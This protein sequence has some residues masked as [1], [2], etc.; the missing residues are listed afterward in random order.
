MHGGDSM[1]ENETKLKSGS[2]IFLNMLVN[3]RER[4]HQN[5]F[6]E[7]KYHCNDNS[8]VAIICSPMMEL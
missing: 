5:S 3:D 8:V 4:Q 6:Q 2:H 7:G 1:T